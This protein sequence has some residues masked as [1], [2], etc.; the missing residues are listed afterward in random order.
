V[1]RFKE[2]L[3]NKL[4]NQFERDLFVGSELR[5]LRPGT[6]ILDA[7]AGSQRYRK[8]CGHLIYKA[9]DFGKYH[10]DIKIRFDQIKRQSLVAS[11]KTVGRDYVYGPID[12]EGDIWKI[13]VM[14]ESF[15]SILCTEVFE[16]IPYPNETLEEFFRILKPGGKIIVTAP[17]NSLRHF[18][19]YFFYTG[20][21]DRWFEHIL[22]KNNYVDIKIIPVQDYYRWMAIEILRTAR[23]NSFFAKIILA[24]SAIYFLLKKPT[25]ESIN[26]LCSG[27]FVTANKPIY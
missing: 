4:N 8:M 25:T 3:I 19:P 10:S 20:F 26:T 23:A 1:N 21:S 18:D 24:Q 2:K 14:N 6:S 12:Y 15:D 27:Y 11:E 22:K 5:M 13:D 9:Q 7:G 17:S 16:H